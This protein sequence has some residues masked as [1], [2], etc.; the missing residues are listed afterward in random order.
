MS[1]IFQP[2]QQINPI[3]SF[4]QGFGA[5]QGIQNQLLQT[6]ERQFGLQQAQLQA[7]QQ[8]EAQIAEQQQAE[9][10]NRLYGIIHSGEGTAQ[11]YINLG[12]MLP[13]AQS[14]ALQESFSLMTDEQNN[15][16]LK[17][18]GQ[19]FSAFKS[20]R[21][22]VA[23]DLIDNLKT[24]YQNSGDEDGAKLMDTWSKVAKSGEE[25]AKSAEA[26][27]G[28]TMGQIPGGK[29]AIDSA[30]NLGKESRTIE[31]QPG[32]IKKQLLD[33]GK[34][35]AETNKLLVETK[36]LNNEIQASLNRNKGIIPE[37]EKIGYQ[38]DIRSEFLK[39]TATSR[40]AATKVNKINAV[41]D[42]AIANGSKDTAVQGV[43]DLALINSFQRLIDDGVVRGEDVT[44][45]MNTAGKGAK[46][47]NAWNNF[48]KGDVLDANQRLEFK[49]VAQILAEQERKSIDTMKNVY[50]PQM[51][52]LGLS[53]LET[54]GDDGTIDPELQGLKDF[55]K[56]NNPGVTGV[57]SMTEEDIKTRFPNGYASYSGNSSGTS[58]IIEVD[59]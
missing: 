48:T 45:A 19:V 25:G 13:A 15:N 18:T 27:F 38:N 39:Y 10:R 26:F 12:S 32:V 56:A 52:T 3:Q 24:A 49:E 29:E 17:E 23:I 53:E 20:G 57:E 11:D 8:Q 31:L 5:G 55:V 28:F 42:R 9:E 40:D 51:K 2:T 43:S 6:K 7:Q 1:D 14:K 35:E 21:S 44:L 4:T 50:R 41:A 37:K 36:K 34:T 22:D 16:T 33:A 54:F 58:G 59:F 47:A 46:L 30:I